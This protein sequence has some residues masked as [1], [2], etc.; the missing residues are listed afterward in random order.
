MR[1]LQ[2]KYK[3]IQEGTFS[4]EQFLRDVR[5]AHPKLVTQYNGYDDAISIL[6]NKGMIYESTEEEDLLEKAPSEDVKSD[7]KDKTESVKEAR[8]TKN[9]LV[10]YR[11]KPTNE[12]DKYPYEQILRGIRVELEEMAVHCTP[13]PEEYKKALARVL[14]NLVKDEIYYTNQ[15]ANKKSNEDLHDKMITIGKDNFEDKANGMKKL[16]LKEGIKTLIVNLLKEDTQEDELYELFSSDNDEEEDEFDKNW[17]RGNVISY[18]TSKLG[19]PNVKASGQSYGNNPEW[20]LDA[21]DSN[22]N[23][24][25]HIGIT[26]KGVVD[27]YKKTITDKGKAYWEDVESA[28]NYEDLKWLLT[29][30]VKNKK[31]KK[32]G[33]G[34]DSL[35]EEEELSEAPATNDPKIERLVNGINDMINKAVDSDGDPIGVIEPGGTWDEPYQYFPIEYKNGQLKITSKSLYSNDPKSDIILAR[36]MELDG[37]PTLRLIMRMYKKA[38]KQPSN[39]EESLVTFKDLLK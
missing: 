17:S 37:L 10:D 34:N 32:I 30:Y 7:S 16:S 22:K 35:Y 39:L 29:D 23:T 12:M 13:T 20:F 11:Y 4:K 5:L 3:G 25:Y 9:S 38:L 15:L 33:G 28:D 21:S 36:N 1:T 6:K 14:K 26:P 31:Y 19:N 2:E 27:L 8:L 24:T 18:I